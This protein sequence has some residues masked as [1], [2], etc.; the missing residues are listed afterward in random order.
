LFGTCPPGDTR[1]Q[2]SKALVRPEHTV[3]IQYGALPYRFAETG[4]L[5]ILLVTSRNTHRWII[6]KGWPTRGMKPARSAAREAYEEAGVRGDV[7]AKAIGAF[8]YDKQLDGER[9]AIPCEVRVFPL[10]VKRQARTWPEADERESRWLNIDEAAVIV[11]DA[12]LC[13]LIQ[14]FAARTNRKTGK[15]KSL[16]MPTASAYGE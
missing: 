11:D 2:T 8:N 7:G 16:R 14:S 10:L 4:A 13:L 5:Q 12:G 9:G 3:R 6:P 15:I 1:F